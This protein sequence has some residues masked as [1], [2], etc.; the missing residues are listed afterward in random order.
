MSTKLEVTGER[1]IEASYRESLSGQVIYL[2]HV[3]S[4]E[5]VLPYCRNKRVLDLG[6][7]SGY[8]AA[9][10]AEVATSVRAVDVSAEAIQYAGEHYPRENIHYEAI[11]P[12]VPLPFSDGQFDVV[13]SFQVIEH[14]CSDA[15]YLAEAARVLGAGGVLILITPDRLLRLLPGQK[16]WNRWHLREYSAATLQDLVSRS[17]EVQSLLRMEADEAL[18]RVETRRYSRLRWLA[19]PF[20]FPGAPEVLR[21][22]GLGLLHRIKQSRQAVSQLPPDPSLGIHSIRFVPE[23]ASSLNLLVLAHP[24]P[25][26][27]PAIAVLASQ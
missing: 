17:F 1:L 22:W 14:V 19:L 9:R 24:T 7:G 13:L 6:C 8:G 2:M 4:Y 15:A 3:A 27:Q 20:T 21:Q 16:P 11:S 25:K 10:V 23:S 18:T 26:P 12:D 5:F